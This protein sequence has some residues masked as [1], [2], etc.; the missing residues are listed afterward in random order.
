V[1]RAALREIRERKAARLVRM[2][3][4]KVVRPVNAKEVGTSVERSR[5]ADGNPAVIVESGRIEKFPRVRRR[6]DKR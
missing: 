4:G 3:Q 2:K 1:R 5:R 6:M